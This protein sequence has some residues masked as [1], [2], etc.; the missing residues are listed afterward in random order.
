M[1]IT[2]R[3]IKKFRAACARAIQTSAQYLVI[4]QVTLFDNGIYRVQASYKGRFPYCFLVQLNDFVVVKY[5][6]ES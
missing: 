3:E 6:R 2:E 5:W 4:R 1:T